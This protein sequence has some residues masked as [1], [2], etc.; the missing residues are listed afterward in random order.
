MPQFVLKNFEL[1]NEEAL[2]LGDVVRLDVGSRRIYLVR[3]P[4]AFQH[5]LGDTYTNH[6]KSSFASTR[7]VSGGKTFINLEGD[8]WLHRRGML[9]FY[10]HRTYMEHVSARMNGA[11]EQQ[12]AAFDHAARSSACLD[13]TQLLPLGKA[14]PQG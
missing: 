4:V 3:H 12:V 1:L 7:R 13:I 10:F 6:R 14:R 8:E 2:R 5:I 9:Q 11:I